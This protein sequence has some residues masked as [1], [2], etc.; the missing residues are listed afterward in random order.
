M[1]NP[2]RIVTTTVRVRGGV[3]PVV[4]VKTSI[5]I[6]KTKIFECMEAIR[7]ICP[8]APVAIGEVL[9]ENIAGTGADLVATASLLA[10]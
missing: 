9:A 10:K 4:P 2:T 5:D 1:T 8:K 6:P 3:H 7:T